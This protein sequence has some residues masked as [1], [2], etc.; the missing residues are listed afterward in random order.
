MSPGTHRVI[1][2]LALAILA[3]PARQT[4][5]ANFEQANADFRRF[6][7]TTMHEQR[8]PGLQV[9]VVKDHRIVLSETYGLANV[10]NKVAATNTTLFPLNSATKSFTAVAVMQLAQSGRVDL[11]APISAYLDDL[12]QAWRG[13]RIRQL[14]AHTSGLP[15]ILDEQGLIGDGT[16]R[17]AWAAVQ[18]LPM[19]AAVGERFAYNQTNYVLL[20]RLIAKQSKQ[21]YAQY[22]RAHQFDVAGMPTSTF[23]DSYDLTPNAATIYSWL[24][25]KSDAQGDAERLSHWFYDVPPTLWS[26]AGIQTTADEVAHWMLALSDGRL[27]PADAVRAMWAPEPLNDGSE[28]DWAAGWPLLGTP[29]QRQVASMG[30]ARAAFIVY[31]DENLAVIVLTNLVGANPQNFIPE[32]ARF[33]QVQPHR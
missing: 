12:P 25:R 30:G 22:L 23:G 26:G 16:E 5:A 14:L 33:Y 3:F 17:G 29:Q 20:A 21:S 18:Q 6:V 19:A 8:I 27:M 15:D 31:P 13:V 7:R 2:L 10:E 4:R 32:I 1:I 28:G 9:A 24:P 11:Q